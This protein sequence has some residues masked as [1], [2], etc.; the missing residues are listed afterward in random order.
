MNTKYLKPSMLLIAAVFLAFSLASCGGGGYGGGSSAGPALT[1]ISFSSALYGSSEVPSNMSAASGSG[2]A[3]VAIASK[4][5][6]ATVTTTGI[7]GTAAHIHEGAVG[8]SGPIIF[9]LAEM[10]SGSGKWS[11]SVTLTDAQLATL[12]AGG[13]Y[14]N[15][16]S[17][18][19]PAGEIR[20]QILMIGTGY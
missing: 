17:A 14:F 11:T 9:P 5:L 4:A 3:T 18:A 7:V 20:G 19:Y 10:P 12:K 16:H 1:M 13:Y 8:V 15:V 2:S 6:M